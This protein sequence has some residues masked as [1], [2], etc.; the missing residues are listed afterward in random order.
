MFFFLGRLPQLAQRLGHVARLLLE[1][2]LQ[3]G[4]R[5][6]LRGEVR[7]SL[8]GA[9]LLRF[10][11]LKARLDL[12]QLIL[13]D[14][15]ASLLSC[16]FGNRDVSGDAGR[17][18]ERGRKFNLEGR[19][20]TRC[21]GGVVTMGNHRAVRTLSHFMYGVGSAGAELFAPPPVP[22]FTLMASVKL[23]SRG[24]SLAFTWKRLEIFSRWRPIF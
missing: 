2:G 3:L 15:R 16:E 22:P 13:G 17:V 23:R 4:Q 6:L 24:A 10:G 7:D 9:L 12:L 18:I 11:G 8:V 14:L 5:G 19:D 20:R 21:V 1:L